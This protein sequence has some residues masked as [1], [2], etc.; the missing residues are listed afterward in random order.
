MGVVFTS[1]C[2]FLA[3]QK[4]IVEELWQK[5]FS[6]PSQWW[7]HRSENVSGD[8]LSI[9]VRVI[10]LFVNVWHCKYSVHGWLSSCNVLLACMKSVCSRWS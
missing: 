2:V 5:F 6:D 3:G 10:T 4:R 9:T 7:D 8:Y 1:S